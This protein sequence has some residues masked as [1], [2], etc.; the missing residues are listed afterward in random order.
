M[1]TEKKKRKTCIFISDKPSLRQR[2]FKLLCPHHENIQWPGFFKR[3]HHVPGYIVLLFNN[4]CQNN[5]IIS[6]YNHVFFLKRVRVS[7]V[8][9]YR[10]DPWLFNVQITQKYVIDTEARHKMLLHLDFKLT[11]DFKDCCKKSNEHLL[12]FVHRKGCD[13]I[14][15]H[16]VI[17]SVCVSVLFEHFQYI[18][19]KPRENRSLWSLGS[20]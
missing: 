19:T 10:L 11:T 6:K 5:Y 13:V 4:I 2:F 7:A 20:M 18:L 14:S 17:I 1:I 3:L 8:W 15:F 9:L 16:F 12:I